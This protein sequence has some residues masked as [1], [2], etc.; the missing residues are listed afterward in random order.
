MKDD[1]KFDDVAKEL[2]TREVVTLQTETR[3]LKNDVERLEQ[4]LKT[5]RDGLAF[6]TADHFSVDD[7]VKTNGRGIRSFSS[8]M[9]TIREIDGSQIKT[10]S[11]LC[12][13]SYLFTLIKRVGK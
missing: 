4:M 6:L 2:L 10:L 7:I 1:A 12:G 13:P 3:N 9:E 11:G 8:D 5:Y